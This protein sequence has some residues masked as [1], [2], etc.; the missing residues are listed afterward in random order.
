MKKQIYTLST[1]HKATKTLTEFSKTL[2]S[3]LIVNFNM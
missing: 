2:D 3:G 1:K